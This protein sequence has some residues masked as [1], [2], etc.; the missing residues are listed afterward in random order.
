VQLLDDNP[1]TEDLLGFGPMVR[2]LT[3]VIRDPP[4]LPFTIGIFGEWGSGKTTLMEMVR[5]ALERQR[6][7]T[8]WFN[9]WKYDGKEVIWNALIQEIFLKMQQDAPRSRGAEFKQRVQ[10]AAGELAKYAAK[11]ATRFVPGGI[12]R[13]D[14]VDAVLA[15]LGSSANDQLF[16]FMN[17]FEDTFNALVRE[18]V[19]E[20]R[21]MVVF[22]DDLDR[23]L[24]ENAINAMEALKL[25][26]DRADC[27]FVVG[28]ESAVIEQGIRHR[29]SDNA[30]LSAREYL[31]KIVQLPFVM[32]RIEPAN[33]LRLLDRYEKTLEYRNDPVIRE[34]IIAGTDANPRRIKRFV[35]A[36]WVL[37]QRV[38]S[39]PHAHQQLLAKVLLI[40]MRFPEIYAELTEDLGLAERLTHTLKEPPGKQR[41][42]AAEVGEPFSTFLTDRDLT[43]FLRATSQ[44]AVDEDSIRPWVLLTQ[45]HASDATA[46]VKRARR[47]G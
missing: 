28:A 47:S 29:Y 30:R 2:I 27:I 7:K 33:A 22:I 25:Y 43:R 41:S 23:C 10:H 34:L 26:L 36:F 46:T 8:V 1:A 3:Q 38:G 6:V 13:E 16:Q 32:P 14:D 39:L 9:A 19:G 21:Y 20:G 42:V 11:V 31:E 17:R 45:G 40:Q 5:A 37:S 44:V 12:L 15:A 18:Y 35:N 4:R 24:P